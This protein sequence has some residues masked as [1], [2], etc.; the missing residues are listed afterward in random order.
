LFI[1]KV[2]IICPDHGEFSQLPSGH[3]AGKGCKK[4]S[5]TSGGFSRSDFVRVAN[6]NNI[7]S[8][9][10]YIIECNGNGESFIKVGITTSTVKYRFSGA[11][12]PYDYSIISEIYAPPEDIYDLEVEIKGKFKESKY[13][14]KVS[15][16]GETECFTTDS[17]EG[18]INMIKSSF[19]YTNKD[20]N[21]PRK[22]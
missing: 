18:I 16:Q 3:L 19:I 17:S 8:V 21:E 20:H 2:T 9:V 1:T 11:K 4:C 22:T 13:R 15:F 6:R 5:D 7:S 10:L 14:P 12:F